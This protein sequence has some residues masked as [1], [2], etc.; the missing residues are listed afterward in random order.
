[1]TGGGAPAKN[2][3]RVVHGTGF[4]LAIVGL[5]GFAFAA[6][7]LVQP[8]GTAHGP[9]FYD[10]YNAGI[11]VKCILV[12]DPIPS[13]ADGRVDVYRAM[14]DECGL[15]ED[16]VS[17]LQSPR[18][19]EPGP[20]VA[21]VEAGDYARFAWERA[22][23]RDFANATDP[24]PVLWSTGEYDGERLVAFSDGSVRVIEEEQLRKLVR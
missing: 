21:D 9:W 23:V 18:S 22:R 12:Q 2:A 14:I 5:G 15:H 24:A 8:R 19:D 6:L 16:M 10:W 17:W 3:P 7:W 13:T 4:V 11:M 20:T 1:M